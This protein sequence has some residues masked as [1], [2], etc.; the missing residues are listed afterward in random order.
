MNIRDFARMNL[1]AVLAI[2]IAVP[3]SLEA[4]RDPGFDEG[5]TGLALALRRLPVTAS[6]LQTTAHPDDED[7]PLFVML[8]RG[9][10]FRTGLLT[11]TRGDGGQNEIGPELFQALG[12]IRTGE[13]EAV[14]RYDGAAQ[15]FTRAFEFGYSF[16][17][18]E[19]FQKWGREEILADLVRV[20]RTFRPDVIT[21]LPRTGTGGGQHHQA[22]G[23]LTEEAFRAAADPARFPEQIRQGLRPWQARKIY[24]RAGWGEGGESQEGPAAVQMEAWAYDPVL[25]RTWAEVG[26]EARSMHRCQGMSQILP[27][28]SQYGS[29]YR[30]IDAEPAASAEEQDLF[31][32]IETGLR[33]FLLLAG[34][35]SAKLGFL[36]AEIAA[37]ERD[38]AQ[39]TASF[40]A[41]DPGKT[42][43]PLVS[44][45]KRVREIS[46]QV[47][48]TPIDEQVKYE[49][50]FALRN[51][52]SDFEEALRLAHQLRVDAVADDGTLVPGQT[53]ELTVNASNGSRRKVAVTRIS[54]TQAR[55]AW[56]FEG[57]AE[58]FWELDAGDAR[59]VRFRV[60]VPDSIGPTQPHWVRNMAVDR[61]DIRQGADPTIPWEAPAIRVQVTYEIDGARLNSRLTPVKYRYQGPWV[62]GEQRHEIMIVPEVSLRVAPDISILPLSSAA[63]G[64]EIRVSA[65]N[66]T[67]GALAGVLRPDLPQGWTAV[68]PRHEVSFEREGQSITKIFRVFP[69]AGL[70]EGDFAIRFAGIFNGKEYRQGHQA[71][72]YHHIQRRH[73]YHPAE[74]IVRMVSLDVSPGIRLGYVM[75][76]GDRVPEALR[77]LGVAYELLTEEDLAFSDLGRFHVIVTGV[78]AYENREDLKAYNRR[79]LDWVEAGGVMLVQYNKFEFNDAQPGQGGQRRMGDSPYAPF[80]AQIGRGRVTDETAPVV[81]LEPE[82]PVFNYPNRIG[83][84]DW[85]GWVQERGLYFLDR[86]DARYVDLVSTSDPFEYN[87]GE[88]R[89]ALVEAEYGKGRWIYIGLGLWRQLP[90]GVPGAYRILANLLSLPETGAAR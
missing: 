23:R 33:R 9:R 17:V 30:L 79:L 53:F 42:V 40:D 67:K 63:G 49:L 74:A 5:A 34:A 66:H 90:A 88:K 78:R 32:G 86:K 60:T 28:P 70:A 36:G 55:G 10:G 1:M 6:F 7:N 26:G 82:H 3:A 48:V 71:I 52:E 19:T 85:A 47:T 72:D 12:I 81:L 2:M 24:E 31:E 18:E 15:F 38:V 13:L 21:T 69:P 25:G 89:G 35:E 45:L 75:G 16:S 41:T 50:L 39:A 20:I 65:L 11:L 62:G 59:E 43:P 27:L 61:Y 4:Q 73:L 51:K 46:R 56:E 54:F 64:R 29:R 87:R 37:L 76:V 57:Q 77:Q 22:T 80:P 68:P 44:G 8:G 84:S 83:D 58:T 14:H